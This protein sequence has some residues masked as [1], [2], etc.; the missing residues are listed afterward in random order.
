ML[1]VG[2]LT[3]VSIAGG[4]FKFQ[5]KNYQ[6]ELTNCEY[7]EDFESVMK[8]YRTLIGN[9]INKLSENRINSVKGSLVNCQLR[10]IIE[11][12]VGL[13]TAPF[14]AYGVSNTLAGCFPEAANWGENFRIKI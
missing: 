1:F 8:S 9:F 11:V 12:F 4:Y 2:A 5:L 7:R 13:L 3:T 10:M 6:Y 14:L